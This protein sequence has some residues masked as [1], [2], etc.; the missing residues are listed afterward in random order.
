MS[1]TWLPYTQ[2]YC[3][4]LASCRTICSCLGPGGFDEEIVLELVCGFRVD[5]WRYTSW[6]CPGTGRA[7]DLGAVRGS[8]CLLELQV[9]G[10]FHE[11]WVYSWFFVFVVADVLVGRAASSSGLSFRAVEVPESQFVKRYTAFLHGN[12]DRYP[13][14]K[15]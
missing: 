13:Q 8:C 2:K 12:R 15:L 11:Q 4:N 3:A 1:W 9:V 6:Q 7:S 5:F 14:C 10:R